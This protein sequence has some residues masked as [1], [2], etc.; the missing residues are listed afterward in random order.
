MKVGTG[1]NWLWIRSIVGVGVS[2]NDEEILG[3]LM[4][5]ND[6]TN[7]HLVPA[8]G[9]SCIMHSFDIQFCVLCAT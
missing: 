7:P 1:Y 2:N 8:V 9:K 3:S 5:K 6:L 4:S